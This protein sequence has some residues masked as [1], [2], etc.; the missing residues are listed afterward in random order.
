M[1]CDLVGFS[2]DGMLRSSYFKREIAHFIKLRRLKCFLLH[3]RKEMLVVGDMLFIHFGLETFNLT[4]FLT[5]LLYLWNKLL[6]Q[7][8]TNENR[9][10][11][12]GVGAL[13]KVGTHRVLCLHNPRFDSIKKPT[14]IELGKGIKS[15][16]FK[17][18]DQENENPFLVFLT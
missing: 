15:F 13:D 12:T 9:I 17:S 14:E 11:K 7:S 3:Q 1:T 8:T 5:H 2:I 16:C 18:L 10:T 4:L 6:I